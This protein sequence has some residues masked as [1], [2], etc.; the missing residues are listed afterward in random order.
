MTDSGYE[1]LTEDI[2]GYLGR[3]MDTGEANAVKAIWYFCL[4]L[5]AKKQELAQENGRNIVYDSE[6]R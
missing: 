4:G 6:M 2:E 5:K 3:S 1:L